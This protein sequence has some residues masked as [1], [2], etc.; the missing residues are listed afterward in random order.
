MKIIPYILMADSF[1]TNMTFYLRGFKDYRSNLGGFF[2]LSIYV[3]SLV[4]GIYLARELWEKSSP[5]IST[6][7]GINSNPSKLYYPKDIFFM[8][9]LTIDSVPYINE[10]IYRPLG[11]IRRKIN[12]TETLLTKNLS[13]ETCNNIFN[14]KYK[15]YDSIK[16]LNLSNF[17]CIS[18][19]KDKNN[20]IE[21]EELYINEFWG[22]DGFQMLQIKLYNCSALAENKEQCESNNIIHEKLKS[23]I[24]TYYSLN[25][26]I[27]TNNYTNPY[28]R[29]I[30]D[31]FYY[32]SYK[33]YYSVTQYLKH[34]QIHSDVG[35]IFKEEEINA[36]NSVHSMVEY[37]ENEQDDGKLFTMSIQL[38][39][40]IDIYNRSYYKIQDLGADVGAIFGVLHLIIGIIFKYYNT[41]KFFVNIINN[42]FF[43]K[44]DFKPFGRNKK[45]FIKL[46]E[47][48]YNDLKLNISFEANSSISLNQDKKNKE[49]F[50]K[51]N[52]S[53][54]EENFRQILIKNKR[55]SNT[56]EAKNN[57]IIKNMTQKMKTVEIN[58]KNYYLKILKGKEKKNNIK[59]YFSVLDRLFCLHFIDLCKNKLNRYSYYNLFYKGKDY[60]INLLDIIN[61]L[62][63]TQFLQMFFFLHEKEKK[64]LYEYIAKP[65]LSS[66]YVGPRFEVE[67]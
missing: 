4:F 64:D 24:I 61:Y 13:L 32:I 22:N 28:V 18:I 49:D 38:T 54:D 6:S 42:F 59:I 63:N 30:E 35:L 62:K 57:N 44:E 10:K 48:L 7:T 65:V 37:T 21:Q 50:M 39:N 15:Y 31:N 52:D 58:N 56:V 46:K 53:L 29:G 12:G 27:D 45:A 36:D 67:R 19:D 34:I 16:H 25:N 23:A 51:E 14:E 66:N 55:I 47:K 17:Y 20:G 60:I 3:I 2:T 33:K 9:T 5:K 43:I 11:H 1:G 40:K 26:Y 8:I 41:S